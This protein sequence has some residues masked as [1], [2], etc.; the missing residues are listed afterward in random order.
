MSH[1]TKSGQ[2]L[3]IKIENIVFPIYAYVLIPGHPSQL[4]IWTRLIEIWN[5]LQLPMKS[6]PITTKVVISN[7]AHGKM[8][9]VQHYVINFV[10]ESIFKNKNWKHCVSHMCL[11]TDTRTSFPVSNMNQV[12]WDLELIV[13]LWFR[14]PLMARCTWYNI[15]WSI[16]SVTCGRS[17]VFSGYSGFL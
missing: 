14:I 17:V 8:Y 10:S 15:M 6:E 12:N 3:K 7:P 13:K 2:Y 5:L 1:Y 4:A 16:L 9:L 11:C